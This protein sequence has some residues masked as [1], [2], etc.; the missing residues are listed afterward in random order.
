[1]TGYRSL[2]ATQFG[3]QRDA[4]LEEGSARVEG[5]LLVIAGCFVFASAITLSL[6]TEGRVT[7]TH[8]YAPA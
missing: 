2:I 8:L 3:V 7:R 4:I 5:I 6:A 1:M